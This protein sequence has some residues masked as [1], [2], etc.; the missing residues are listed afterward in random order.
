MSTFLIINKS[1]NFKQLFRRFCRLPSPHPLMHESIDELQIRKPITYTLKKR[2]QTNTLKLIF[3][4][5]KPHFI[6]IKSQM[7]CPAALMSAS[8][9]LSLFPK[10]SLYEIL[11]NSGWIVL[12]CVLLRTKLFILHS[13][14]DECVSECSSRINN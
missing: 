8:L 13:M 14:L 9:S 6:N 1:H 4:I 5:F 2:N 7:C 3:Y 10:L 11:E 12:F